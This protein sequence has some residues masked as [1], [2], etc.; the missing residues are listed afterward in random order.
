VGSASRK[1]STTWAS[2]TSAGS[3]EPDVF[4][5][6]GRRCG[7][8][9]GRSSGSEDGA[10]ASHAPAPFLCRG[11]WLASA[12]RGTSHTM[13]CRPMCTSGRLSKG[14]R[15]TRLTGRYGVEASGGSRWDRM[16]RLEKRGFS[17][18]A[19]QHP[20]PEQGLTSG[21][22]AGAQCVSSA[23]WDLCGGRPEPMAPCSAGEGPSLPRNR[24]P[25]R[26]EKPSIPPGCVARAS[27]LHDRRAGARD[28]RGRSLGAAESTP[29]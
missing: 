5:W 29:R 22:E 26:P 15:A 17:P 27:N 10:D 19:I 3:H 11:A 12:V 4:C 24:I 23:R 2:R 6:S 7:S 1:R 8:G 16:S 13:P 18:A 28:R 20:W 21:P 25:G 14:S 9:C